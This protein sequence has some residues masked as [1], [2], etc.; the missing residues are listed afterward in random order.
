MPHTLLHFNQT[1]MCE[2][3]TKIVTRHTDKNTVSY[4]QI[5]ETILNLNGQLHGKDRQ[6][7]VSS[8][9]TPTPQ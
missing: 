1:I 7:P 5:S 6:S 2:D 9:N 4:S 3:I 8:L